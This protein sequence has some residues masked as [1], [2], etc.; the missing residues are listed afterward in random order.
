MKWKLRA[1]FSNYTLLEAVFMKKFTFRPLILG[2]NL[3]TTRAKQLGL[4]DL[5]KTL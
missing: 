1:K 5:A 3:T 4:K 2:K